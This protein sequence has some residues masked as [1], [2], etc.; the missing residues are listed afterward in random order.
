MENH[1]LLTKQNIEKVFWEAQQRKV[2]AEIGF[3]FP[4]LFNDTTIIKRWEFIGCEITNSGL[5]TM[6]FLVPMIYD[7]L[8]IYRAQPFNLIRSVD[9]QVCK[10]HYSGPKYMIYNERNDC[11]KEIEINP[12]KEVQ[13]FFINQPEKCEEINKD[14]TNL[15]KKGFC[16]QNKDIDQ[17]DADELQIHYG[18]AFMYVYC[19]NQTLV[20]FNLTMSCENKIYRLATDQ[21]FRVGNYEQRTGKRKIF[22]MMTLDVH[23]NIL[24]NNHL[25]QKNQKYEISSKNLEEL[26]DESEIT[27]IE[28]SE[29]EN[30]RH[31]IINIVLLIMVLLGSTIGAIIYFW[32][33][34]KNK[35]LV[36]QAVKVVEEV[37]LHDLEHSQMNIT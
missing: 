37:H 25:F 28:S 33:Y 31:K 15:W 16:K 24:M 1:L 30:L 36:N 9:D 2:I 7:D 26:L 34:R 22:G 11:V 23:E 35:K 13:T 12:Y 6:E 32:I 8:I 27:T 17:T 18:N 19:F 20:V 4:H 14:G 21:P 5:L 3:L 29:T 10:F